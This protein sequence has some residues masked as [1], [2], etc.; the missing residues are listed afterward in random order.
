MTGWQCP[1]CGRCYSNYLVMC[2]YCQPTGDATDTTGTSYTVSQSPHTWRQ[3]SSRPDF[4]DDKN[5]K[6]S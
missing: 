2:P 1:K 4:F 3:G 6:D 5:S